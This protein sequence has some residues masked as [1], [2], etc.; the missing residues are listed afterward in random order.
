MKQ[1]V[2]VQVLI[3]HHD[4]YLLFGYKHFD[5][6]KEGYLDLVGGTVI[7]GEILTAGLK[8]EVKEKVHIELDDRDIRPVDFDS[9]VMTYK[10]KMTH[11]IFLR[12]FAEIDH[13]SAYANE[14]NKIYWIREGE[15][16]EHE[17]TC[18]TERFLRKMALIA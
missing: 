16:M 11:V 14:K 18:S 7:G 8:R 15:L 3:K 5:K 13:E 10:G 17:F 12:Y 1:R 9:E 6:H 2:V 4:K